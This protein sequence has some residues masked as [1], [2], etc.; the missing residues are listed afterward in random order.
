MAAEV[1]LAH[2]GY[3]F[4][5]ALAVVGLEKLMAALREFRPGCALPILPTLVFFG[6]TAAVAKLWSC[7]RN[8][9]GRYLPHCA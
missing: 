1:S 6:I 2:F 5:P 4:K 9:A 7:Y 8:W 3:N